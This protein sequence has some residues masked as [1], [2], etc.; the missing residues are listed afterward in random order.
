MREWLDLETEGLNVVGLSRSLVAWNR[1]IDELN[2]FKSE[3][4]F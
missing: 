1:R 3:K 2:S 4:T